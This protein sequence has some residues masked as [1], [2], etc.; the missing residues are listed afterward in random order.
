M[1]EVFLALVRPKLDGHSL[2]SIVQSLGHLEEL[3]IAGDH[4]PLDVEAE[5]ALQRHERGEELGDPASSSGRAQ[6][7]HSQPP[8]A[9][10][11]IT[12]SGDLLI[13]DDLAVR[14]ERL[15]PYLHALGGCPHTRTA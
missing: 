12:N 4:L 3:A 6:L 15:A 10:S 2:Q 1:V 13:A 5:I 8:Q 7:E 14:L 9:V 11:K